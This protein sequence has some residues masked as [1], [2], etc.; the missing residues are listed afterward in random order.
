MTF[1]KKAKLASEARHARG[2]AALTKAEATRG[3]LL[4]YHRMLCAHDPDLMAAYDS[5]YYELTLV[6]RSFS[7][8]EREVVW[9]VLLAAAR[10]A[11]GDIH[12][13]RAEESGMNRAQIHDCMA[14]AGVAEAFPAMEFSTSWSKWIVVDEIELRYGRMVELARGELPA[15]IAEIALL[16]GHAARGSRAGMR[17]HL[18]RAFD[19]GATAAKIAEGVSYVILPKGGPA[20]VAACDVWAELAAEGVCPAP[21]HVR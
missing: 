7:Y 18:K 11:Y 21:W 16:V 5:Y 8:F 20:L 17:F 6:E 9:L 15:E 19:M 3:Y 12:M 13:P 2:V 1:I 4:P 14:L 10:E